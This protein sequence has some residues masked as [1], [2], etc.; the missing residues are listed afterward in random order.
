MAKTSLP[1]PQSAGP[2]R[3]PR[4][5]VA[6]T[7]ESRRL[8][9]GDCRTQLA[10]LF[11]YLDGELTASRCRAIERHLRECPCCDTLASGVRRAIAICRGAG[12]ERLPS[13]VRTRAQTRIQRLLGVTPLPRGRAGRQ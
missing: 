9:T 12:R 3:T 5:R 8:P 4:E 10:E 11:A 1:R 2:R 13:A 7:D 6:R